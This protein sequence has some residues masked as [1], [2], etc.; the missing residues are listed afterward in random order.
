VSDLGCC[1]GGSGGR[2]MTRRLASTGTEAAAETADDEALDG[3]Q[4]VEDGLGTD[5]EVER[6][7]KGRAVVEVA[8]PQL[9]PSELPLAI[10]V[11]LHRTAHTHTCP[12]TV[13]VHWSFYTYMYS[14]IN[15]SINFI[16][17]KQQ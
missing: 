9:G 4:E 16:S 13:H 10:G 15:Q 17:D 8:H 14:S 2:T 3:A 11:V 5:D 12:F 1:D 6:R 7:R